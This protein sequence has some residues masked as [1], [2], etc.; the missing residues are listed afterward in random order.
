MLLLRQ[1]AAKKRILPAMRRCY[2]APSGASIRIPD[3]KTDNVPASLIPPITDSTEAAD[4]LTRFFKSHAGRVLV[5]TGAGEFRYT[6][7]GKKKKILKWAL[8]TGISTDSG[9]PDYRGEQVMTNCSII[10]AAEYNAHI[11]WGLWGNRA[12]I[13]RIQSIVRFSI[14]SLF[15]QK[16]FERDTGHADIL[17]GL[18][19]PTHDPIHRIMPSPG[20]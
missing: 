17:D 6:L 19:W 14:P 8:L 7:L 9:V 13:L 1:C 18:K 2:R 10:P 5:L 3:L 20:S 4:I 12:P 16:T 11:E 15:R